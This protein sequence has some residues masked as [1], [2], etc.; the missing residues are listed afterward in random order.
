MNVL[1]FTT[2]YLIDSL[3]VF[4]FVDHD[5]GVMNLLFFVEMFVSLMLFLHMI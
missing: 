4:V 5:V 2:V 3:S 1:C